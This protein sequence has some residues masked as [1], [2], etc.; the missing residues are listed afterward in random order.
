MQ[1]ASSA[2]WQADRIESDREA[3]KS[4]EIAG[5]LSNSGFSPHRLYGAHEHQLHAL[6]FADA[7]DIRATIPSISRSNTSKL[8]E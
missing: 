3:P 8:A 5:I 6:P 2:I 1:P 4:P 7:H